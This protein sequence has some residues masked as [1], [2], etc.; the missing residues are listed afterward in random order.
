MI[1]PMSHS[2]CA[3]HPAAH[4][5]HE[6]AGRGLADDHHGPLP[7]PAAYVVERLAQRRDLHAGVGLHLLEPA[8][9][10]ERVDLA[11]V[12]GHRGAYVEVGEAGDRAGRAAAGRAGARRCGARPAR[13]ASAA[14]RAVVAGEQHV[15]DVA[16]LPGRG[17]GVDGVLEQAVG[18]RLLD[19]RLG[20]AHE[21]GQ[22]PHDRLGDRQRGHLAAV[23]D[24]VAER[25]LAHRA[26]RGGVL[27]DP[28]VDALVAAARE[29]EVLVAAQLVGDRLGERLAAGGGEDD[30]R[31]LRDR[32][33]APGP[34]AR[35]SSPSR[36]R[37]RTA[38]RRRCGGGRSS[39]RA[40]RG[41]RCRAGPC[42]GPCREG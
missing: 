9:P 17:L 37:R 11:G 27:D 19:Q 35:A 29:D 32:R 18:V 20:V 31:A 22:Q 34:T 39:T 40:G 28:L 7:Q 26:D 24:V 16:A 38:C 21:A 12:G 6:A 15:G 30:R 4:G 41:R 25:D 5:T 13:A 10:L 33:R 8:G 14:I 1:R 2:P 23:E 36:R 3:V 42:R